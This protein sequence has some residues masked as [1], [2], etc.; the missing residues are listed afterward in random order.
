VTSPSPT[1]SPAMSEATNYYRWI[2]DRFRPFIGKQVLEVGVGCGQILPYLPVDTSYYGVDIDADLLRNLEQD[3]DS[4]CRFILAD[5]QGEDFV[6]R[7]AGI[8]VDTVVCFNVLEH[9]DDDAR[10][11]SNLLNTLRPGGYLLIFV[12]AFPG[13]F[14]DLDRLAGHRRRYTLSGLEALV[15]EAL[16]EIVQLCYFNPL[17]WLGW[18]LNRW[19][20]H[21]SLDAVGVSHQIH[22]FDRYILPLSRIVDPLTRRFV[23]QSAICIIRKRGSDVPTASKGQI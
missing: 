8:A 17:G 10:A 14:N 15:P 6:D 13:L 12:P 19:A 1:F 22:F 16:C 20:R 21:Q 7:T 2:I 11:I 23:G 3:D 5:V 9:L 18:L 4:R